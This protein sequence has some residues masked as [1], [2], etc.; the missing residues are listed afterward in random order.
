[1]EECIRERQEFVVPV[2]YNGLGELTGRFTTRAI[3][4]KGGLF[5]PR[6]IDALASL[7]ES[8]WRTVALTYIDLAAPAKLEE[9]TTEQQLMLP[10]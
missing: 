7:R 4:W 3:P 10:L 8:D 5:D 2:S 1:V 9:R 6:Q